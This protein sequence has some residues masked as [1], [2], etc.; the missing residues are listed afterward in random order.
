ML[1]TPHDIREHTLSFCSPPRAV[2]HPPRGIIRGATT[3]LGGGHHIIGRY[4]KNILLPPKDCFGNTAEQ[5][6]KKRKICVFGP[7]KYRPLLDV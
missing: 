5:K 7:T 4:D 3:T 2:S 6:K 1:R